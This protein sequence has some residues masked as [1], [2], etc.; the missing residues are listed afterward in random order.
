MST[1]HKKRTRCQGHQT[2]CERGVPVAMALWITPGLVGYA[3]AGNF[4]PNGLNWRRMEAR[5]ILYDAEDGCL[6][7]I[8]VHPRGKICWN[9]LDPAPNPQYANEKWMYAAVDVYSHKT[10]E[11]FMRPQPD[12]TECNWRI[13]GSSPRWHAGGPSLSNSVPRKNEVQS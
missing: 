5:K 3:Y 12:G 10:K 6:E 1:R 9:I 8:L 11:V 13:Q 7:F 2:K 4:H